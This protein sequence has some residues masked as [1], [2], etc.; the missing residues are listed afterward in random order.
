[1]TDGGAGLVSKGRWV[2]EDTLPLRALWHYNIDT[3]SAT[4]TFA[5]TTCTFTHPRELPSFYSYHSNPP[6][7]ATQGILLRLKEVAL[8]NAGQGI[9]LESTRADSVVLI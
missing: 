2:C 6:L 1:M 5:T 3:V 8:E 9:W 4:T 7:I